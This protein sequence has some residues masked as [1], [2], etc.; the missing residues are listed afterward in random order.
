MPKVATKMVARL[1]SECPGCRKWIAEGTIIKVYNNK[2]FHTK[3]WVDVKN[4]KDNIDGT[5]KIIKK[6]TKPSINHVP[7]HKLILD[8]FT[9]KIIDS[10]GVINKEIE[11][12]WNHIKLSCEREDE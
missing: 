6:F 5:Q 4:R 1:R 8:E 2:W 11:N 10:L 7:N 9:D 3:C 12:I